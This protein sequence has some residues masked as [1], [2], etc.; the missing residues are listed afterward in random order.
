[1]CVG[2]SSPTCHVL[3]FE[4]CTAYTLSGVVLPPL[5]LDNDQILSYSVLES[6]WLVGITASSYLKSQ[7]HQNSAFCTVITHCL[8]T[9]IVHCQI[10]RSDVVFY[11]NFHPLTMHWNPFTQCLKSTCLLTSHRMVSYNN[12]SL[13]SKEVLHYERLFSK[14]VHCHSS[15]MQL[16]IL[17]LIVLQRCRGLYI[18]SSLCI[19]NRC[20]FSS[21]WM[22]NSSNVG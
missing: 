8:T 17:S 11:S 3:F 18:N 15:V 7:T 14:S 12:H 20:L 19:F 21:N 13:L 9:W 1:M 22:Q 2:V 5:N 4:E 6:I 16:Q 10:A